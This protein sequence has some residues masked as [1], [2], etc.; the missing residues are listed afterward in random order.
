[1]DGQGLPRLTNNARGA[2]GPREQ[3]LPAGRGVFE[4]PGATMKKRQRTQ[5][6]DPGRRAAG[7]FA[8][9]DRAL[10]RL[11]RARVEPAA[12]VDAAERQGLLRVGGGLRPL[13]DQMQE[14]RRQAGEREQV[15]PVVLEDRRQRPGVA[16]A[17]KLK[18]PVRGSRSL[19]RHQSAWLPTAAPRGR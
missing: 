13:S 7:A 17:D 4:P 14:T 1:M 16:G 2:A 11:A 3:L 6:I 15:E 19:A 18:V 5:G 9:H 12:C 8:H 10:I